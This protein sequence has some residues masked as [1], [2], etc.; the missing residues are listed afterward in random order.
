[1]T[2]KLAIKPQFRNTVIVNVFSSKYRHTSNFSTSP[3]KYTIL[4]RW[5]IAIV[6]FCCHFQPVAALPSFL[7]PVR[8]NTPAEEIQCYSIPY[9]G[10]GFGSH[11][12]TYWTLAW[13][14]AGKAPWCPWKKLKHVRL[15][16][17][18]GVTSF[19][20]VVGVAAFTIIRCRNRWEYMLIA[21]WKIFMTTVLVG[22]TVTAPCLKR[23][24]DDTRKSMWWILLYIPGVVV[25][26]VGLYPL[27]KE[28]WDNGVVRTISYAF[29]GTALGIGITSGVIF[30]FCKKDGGFVVTWIFGTSI[31]AAAVVALGVLYSD[32]ILGAIAGNL[33][34]FPSSDNLVLYWIYFVAKRLPLLSS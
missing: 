11:I 14:W 18:W 12:L 7:E 30:F 13:L 19:A 5:L 28:S 1:M 21:I 25:G 17:F 34:G 9:G 2:N 29:G 15:D 27:V 23:K 22:T 26:F 31:T 4:L 20:I 16:A 3:Q 8:G 24:M 10:I 6:L 33:V 32:W